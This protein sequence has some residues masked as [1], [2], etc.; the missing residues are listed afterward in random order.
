M[1]EARTG[2]MGIADKLR[3]KLKREPT[4]AEIA[5]AKAH[6]GEA[7]VPGRLV[8]RGGGEAGAA[9][10]PAVVELAPTTRVL[11]KRPRQALMR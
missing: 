11:G 8:V 6:L 7:L 5:D 4:A 1:W 2:N 3:E 10:E 9:G